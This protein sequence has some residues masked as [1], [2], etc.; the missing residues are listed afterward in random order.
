MQT[1]SPLAIHSIV[2]IFGDTSPRIIRLILDFDI[3]VEMDT[4]RTD[5]FL[6]NIILSSRIF[7]NTILISSICFLY[8]YLMVFQC[9]AIQTKG[10]LNAGE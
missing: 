3:P 2:S 9:I 10:Y 7:I 6:S 8:W 4:W 1:F 5:K